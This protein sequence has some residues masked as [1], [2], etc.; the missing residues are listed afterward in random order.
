MESGLLIKM[1]GPLSYSHNCF[2]F[3]TCNTIVSLQYLFSTSSGEFITMSM[4]SLK[5][6]S[7]QFY[8][9]LTFKDVDQKKQKS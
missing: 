1:F 9:Y 2:Q 8:V 4:Y 3:S 7:N 5:V 6:I